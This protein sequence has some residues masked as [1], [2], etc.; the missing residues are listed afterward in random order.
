M[1]AFAIR[2]PLLRKRSPVSLITTFAFTPLFGE[3]T[4]PGADQDSPSAHTATRV[5]T[6]VGDTSYDIQMAVSANVASIGVTWGYHTM[7]ELRRAGAKR[8]VHSFA[9]LASTLDGGAVFAQPYEAV[10]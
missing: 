5:S 8:I 6:G 10:A 1:Y 3:K 2:N 7:A 4:K 9:E